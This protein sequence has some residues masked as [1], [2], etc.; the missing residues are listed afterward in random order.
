MRIIL[1]HEAYRAICHDD[2]SDYET[3]EQ[4]EWVQEYKY[5]YR[6]LIL[7]NTKTGKFYSCTVSRS[8]SP[9]SDWHYGYEDHESLELFEVEKVTKTITVEIWEIVK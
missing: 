4:N 2:Y 3:I 5:Q 1:D 7:K 9:F 6:E 8:G